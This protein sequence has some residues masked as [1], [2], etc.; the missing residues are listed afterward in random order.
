MLHYFFIA[1]VFAI[2]ALADD[3]KPLTRIAFGCCSDQDKPLPIFDKI[4]DQKPELYIAMGDNIY[5]DLKREPGLDEMAS[6]KVKYEKLAALPGWQRLTKTCP[7]LVTWDDHDYGKNDAGAEYPHKEEAQQIF[8]DFFK[9]P[10]DSPRRTQ[11]GVYNAA[12][13]GPPGKRVQIILMDLRYF[14]SKLKKDTRPLPGT[15]IVPYLP[16]TD[17][18][19]TM[20]GAEQWKW[21]EEQFKQPAELR[22]LISSIQLVSDEHPHEKWAN[23]P[24][25]RDRL[26]KLIRDTKAGG[27]VVLSGDR[28]LGEISMDPK[29]V[30]YP[31]FDITSSG[32]NQ[33]TKDWRAPTE[34]NK[35]RIASMAHGDNFGFVTIDWKADPIV[36][37]QVRDVDG[38]IAIKE[39]FPLGLLSPTAVTELPHKPAEGAISPRDALKKIGQKVVIEMKVQ[40]TG[41]PKG[42]GRLFL[43]SEK[44][45]R[46]DLN[47]TIVLNAGALKGKWAKESFKD[48]VIRVTGTV[49]E[50]RGTP[51]VQVD[52]EKQIEIAE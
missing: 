6:M 48:K 43:N 50:F 14:R 5:A 41:Q 12:I 1:I 10:K 37:I 2:P 7:M 17:P 36:S 44:D 24:L 11:K 16:N 49:S 8:L 4:A 27:L 20:L 15:R 42:G 30:G 28:H 34:P 3:A 21:L 9:I 25:E 13:I 45:F 46:S 47:F 18:D 32:L 22:L 39:S 29:A 51:Q 33:G 38:E 52:D 23:L 35:H 31:L 26:Y 19:A 40:A